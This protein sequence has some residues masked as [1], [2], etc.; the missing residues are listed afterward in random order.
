MPSDPFSLDAWTAGAQRVWKSACSATSNGAALNVEHLLWGLLS[1][2]GRAAEQLAQAGVTEDAFLAAWRTV[3]PD[4]DMVLAEDSSCDRHELVDAVVLEARNAAFQQHAGELGTEH[5]LLALCRVT[6]EVS[7]WLAQYSMEPPRAAVEKSAATRSGSEALITSSELQTPWRDPTQTDLFETY[8]IL[9]AAANRAREGLR[10]VEDFV[11]WAWNDSFLSQQLKECRHELTD[12]LRRLPQPILLAARDT[13]A[14]VGTDIRTVSEYRRESPAA[15]ATAS[16]KRVEEALR[17]LEEYS[18]V[19]DAELSPRFEQLRYRLYT[20]DK[21]IH[22]TTAARL[23]LADQQICLLATNSLCHHGL[24][25]AILGALKSGVKLIQLREKSLPD[26]EL[27]EIARHVRQ[28]TKE[29]EGIFIVNDR[30]DIAALVDA[31]GVHVGQDDLSV[32][33]ARKILGGDKLVGVSTHTIEQARQAVLDGA[34]YLGVGP[35]FPSSTKT[36]DEFPGLDF[37]R[38]AA[39]EISLPWY[40]IGG[41]NAENLAEVVAAGATRVAVSSAICSAETPDWAAGEL[42]FR[43]ESRL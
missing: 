15:V 10:V 37:V 9:D 28:W 6:S 30:P 38:Q 40:A 19:V 32:A 26:R 22:T 24:G 27:I 1:V 36:F 12:T 18:K 43:L 34:D 14:D 33:E 11:R 4:S 25:P 5:L 21:A 39:A 8:R 31:D 23:R 42:L 35:V 2:E 41:I 29:F 20:V 7:E 16:L 17:S 13:A 3:D